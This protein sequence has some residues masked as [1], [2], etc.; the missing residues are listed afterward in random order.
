MY[1]KSVDNDA[2][3]VTVRFKGA[4]SGEYIVLLFSVQEA[5]V[6]N[7]NLSITTQSS[8][9]SI[10]PQSGSAMGGTVVT[11]SGENFSNNP[12]DNPVMIGD[13]LCLV[14]SSSASEI[15]CR[16]EIR[17]EASVVPEDGTVSVFLKLGETAKCLDNTCKFVFKEPSGEL[18]SFSASYD[19]SLMNHIFTIQGAGLQNGPATLT[20]GG[21]DQVL[22]TAGDDQ[23]LFA[24]S[25]GMLDVWTDDISFT[26]G[27]GYPKGY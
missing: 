27:D 15:V 7:E 16:I 17:D 2:K 3:T 1:V 14:E 6:D 10:S 25:G 20:I 21:V 12:M 24:F 5:R 13:S 26:L 4:P 22:L 8:V 19:S 11:I 9:T 18:T 23:L